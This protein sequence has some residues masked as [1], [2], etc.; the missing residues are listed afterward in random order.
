[1][2]DF[3]LKGFKKEG[4]NNMNIRK[5]IPILCITNGIICLSFVLLG[6]MYHCYEI[7][8]V[9]GFGAGFCLSNAFWQLVFNKDNHNNYDDSIQYK[10]F[11]AKIKYIPEDDCWFG[12]VIN[13]PDKILIS[14]DLY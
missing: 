5:I 9:S 3:L 14:E 13:I 7:M 12:A 4:V 2:A 8:K 1:M 10:G 11:V 6:Y